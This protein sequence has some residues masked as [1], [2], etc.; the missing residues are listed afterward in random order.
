VQLNLLTG[1][2]FDQYVKPGEMTYPKS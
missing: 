2:Q 1:E